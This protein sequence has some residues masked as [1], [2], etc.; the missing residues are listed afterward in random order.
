MSTIKGIHI[1]SADSL[2]SLDALVYQGTALEAGD[3][4][5][6]SIFILRFEHD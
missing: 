4:W 2:Y 5:E 1:S 3:T 6:L